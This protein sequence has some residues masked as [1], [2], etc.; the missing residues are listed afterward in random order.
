MTWWLP[1]RVVRTT[2]VRIPIGPYTHT[3]RLPRHRSTV[4]QQPREETRPAFPVPST[5]R[6]SIHLCLS[7]ATFFCVVICRGSYVDPTTGGNP[8]VACEEQRAPPLQRCSC[9]LL[10]RRQEPE[11][12]LQ[13]SFNTTYHRHMPCGKMIEESS[14]LKTRA[15]DRKA[16]SILCQLWL[17]R[18]R[19][20]STKAGHKDKIIHKQEKLQ[21]VTE[22]RAIGCAGH[23]QEAQG[24]AG[25]AACGAGPAAAVPDPLP[26]A[27]GTGP[28]PSSA[29]TAATMGAAEAAV[30][31][32][33]LGLA[34]C[35][36]AG[37]I[38]GSSDCTPTP[39]AAASARGG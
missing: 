12:R 27:A 18:D 32:A 38:W 25:C 16:F 23:A 2:A 34:G 24:G 26:P 13:N 31:A 8:H 9:F 30:A 29:G 36:P 6:L 15:K 11:K 20:I 1:Q 21:A 35:R 19:P 17:A 7:A 28:A 10:R 14:K 5:T 39:L 37:L 33:T 22:D 4:V 3:S